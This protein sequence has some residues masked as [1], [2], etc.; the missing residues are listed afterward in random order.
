MST[1]ETHRALG[2]ATDLLAEKNTKIERLTRERD[3]YHAALVKISNTSR[4][5]WEFREGQPWGVLH[6]IAADALKESQ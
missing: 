5:D 2:Y 6:I 1:R 4:W 3:R